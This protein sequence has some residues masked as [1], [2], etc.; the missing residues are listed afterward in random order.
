[1]ISLKG[2]EW[3]FAQTMAVSSYEEQAAF[4]N[5]FGRLLPLMCKGSTGTQ[6]QLCMLVSNLDS[7][8]RAIIRELGEFVKLEEENARTS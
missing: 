4:F 2:A 1:M 3:F 5:E 7:S 8:G 6:T